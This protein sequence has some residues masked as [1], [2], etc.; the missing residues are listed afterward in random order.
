MKLASI[1]ALS[2]QQLGVAIGPPLALADEV[3]E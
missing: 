1:V 2:R 3:I